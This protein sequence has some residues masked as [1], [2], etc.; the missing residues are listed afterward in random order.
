MHWPCVGMRVRS[1]AP[2]VW[3]FWKQRHDLAPD[4]AVRMGL[5]VDVDVPLAR[6]KLP[7]LLCRQS[8]PPDDRVS[9]GLPCFASET[10]P[11]AFLLGWAGPWN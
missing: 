8:R 10:R 7:V 11:G 3:A 4:F 2:A 1:A 9:T 5:G 6:R